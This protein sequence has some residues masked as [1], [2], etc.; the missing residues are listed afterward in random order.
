MR[1]PFF[2]ARWLPL[3]AVVLL[4]SGCGNL[5]VLDPQGPVAKQQSHLIILSIGFMIFIVLVVFI[6]FTMMLVK[7][8]DRSDHKG[9]DPSI[10]GSHKLEITWTIIPIII[11]TLLSIPTVM[12]IYQLEEVPEVTAD[13]VE[14]EP[15]VIHATSVNW[16]WIFSYPDEEIETVNYVN[17]PTDRPVLFKLTSADSMASFWVPQLG[18]QKYSMAGMETELYLAATSPGTYD[19][20]NANFTGEGFAEQRFLV[21]ALTHDQ[22]AAWVEEVQSEAPPLSEE[23]YAHLMVPG[24]ATEMTFSST[25]LTFV[26]HVQEPTYALDRRAELGY[27]ALSPH[28]REGKKW[29][30][31]LL[32][33]PID[34][35]KRY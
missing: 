17:I 3:L 10:E 8:R 13:N 11:V 25:H 16:K 20:R 34:I 2:Y 30:M 22:Y 33:Q 21:N 15:L 14:T 27:K 28:S 6:L 35:E 5:T 24:H 29:E 12:T 18:G 7:Y 4:L 23:E 9:Y 26:D 19:G 31:P 1:T 32:S